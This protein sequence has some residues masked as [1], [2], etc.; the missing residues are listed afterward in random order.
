MKQTNHIFVLERIPHKIG[1][2]V[3]NTISVVEE[4]IYN[5]VFEKERSKSK[6]EKVKDNNDGWE[7]PAWANKEKI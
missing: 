3:M 6:K 7:E 2:G 5:N 4:N 1:N